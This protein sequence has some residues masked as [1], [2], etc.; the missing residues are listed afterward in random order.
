MLKDVI[1]SARLE[2]GYTQEEIAKRVKVAKQ[3]Y[4]KWENGETE[5]KATQIKLLAENLNIT[6]NEI[7]SGVKNAK[8]DLED[9]II[10][11]AVSRV[12][13][14]IITMY[15]WKMLPDHE[16]FFEA[17]KSLDKEEYYEAMGEVA[18]LESHYN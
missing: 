16:K 4:L 12:S 18:S 3:T 14:E 1:K 10:Q 17:M 8:L 13:N 9:F 11:L 15:T 7:C 2:C 5:P 6:P